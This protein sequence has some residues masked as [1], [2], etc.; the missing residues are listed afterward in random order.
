MLSAIEKNLTTS[1][2]YDALIHIAK[3]QIDIK[4]FEPQPNNPAAANLD[5]AYS[6]VVDLIE[7]IFVCVQKE[8]SAKVPAVA[9]ADRLGIEV[10]TLKL[11]VQT[12]KQNQTREEK[13]AKGT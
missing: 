10:D 7:K 3:L 13:L 11:E 12:R 9:A 6:G 4:Q 1:N 2:L 5:T 8:E